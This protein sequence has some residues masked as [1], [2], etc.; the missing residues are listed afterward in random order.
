L[1]GK[2]ITLSAIGL[3]IIA[4][5]LSGSRGGTISFFTIFFIWAHYL[6]RKYSFNF[7]RI[8][9]AV[10]IFVAISGAISV[11]C[12]DA[13]R[14][15]VIRTSQHI[16]TLTYR[17]IIWQ[18]LVSAAIKKPVFG[19]GY[20][21]EIFKSDI[22][23]KDTVYK[24]APVR[25]RPGFRNPHNAFLRVLFHQGLV[26]LL[27]YVLLLFIAIKTFLA[28]AYKT[29]DLQSYILIACSSLLIGLFV[30]DSIVENLHLY[31]LM[32][33]LGIGIAAIHIKDENS[34]NS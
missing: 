10:I 3:A 25:L 16:K 4:L 22:P 34:H 26:G 11:S 28:Y 7:K 18:R 21:N 23:F 17:T 31:H 32:P 29:N 33:I 9:A 24:T 12:S 1:K 19:W 20:G 15:K 6:S 2:A 8:T 27:S 14:V 5:L 30:V 13:L